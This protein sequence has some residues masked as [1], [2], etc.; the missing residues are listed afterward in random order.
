[1]SMMTGTRGLNAQMNVT[2]LV[3]VLLVLLVIFMITPR[4]DPH[5]IDAKVPQEATTT[6]HTP[7]PDTT[8]VLQVVQGLG[9]STSL[10]LNREAVAWKDLAPRLRE[11]YKQ[12]ATKVMFI[13]GDNDVEFSHIARALDL[14]R[15]ADRDIAI[16]LLSKD[17]PHVQ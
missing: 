7:P 13:R 14:T 5:G 11:I 16:G 4:S 2:P 15:E 17:L 10:R 1:M 6:D 8:I 9:D 12:R 3:D